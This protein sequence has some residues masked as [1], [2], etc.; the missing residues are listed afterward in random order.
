M[1]I[2]CN[3]VGIM[4]DRNDHIQ[5]L[6]GG[7]GAEPRIVDAIMRIDGVMQ[8]WRRQMTKRELGRR[9][10]RTLDLP[11][12]Q[13][14]LDVLF[15]IAAPIYGTDMAEGEETMVATVAERLGI[16]PSRASRLVGEMVAAGYARRAVSQADARRTIV[17]L[18]EKGLAITDAVRAYRWLMMADY[19][20]SWTED[21]IAR[22]VPL[23]ERYTDWFSDV[24]ASE[25]RLSREIATIAEGAARSVESN[26]S[27][28]KIG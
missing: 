4:P 10:I 1:S 3:F 19:F 27:A 25:L 17:E 11:I 28:L 23:L 2:A 9:A 16:D 22:F 14:Q 5:S 20:S 21:D 15:A 7:V 12:E 26:P 8:H 6:L 18:T 13:A 24:E